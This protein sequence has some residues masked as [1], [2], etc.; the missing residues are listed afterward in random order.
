M[1]P[2]I[3]VSDWCFVSV[4]AKHLLIVVHWQVNLSTC[5]CWPNCTKQVLWYMVPTSLSKLYKNSKCCMRRLITKWATVFL[6]SY[7]S[8][9][10]A[11]DIIDLT[12]KLMFSRS[13]LT[14]IDEDASPCPR[15]YPTTCKRSRRVTTLVEFIAVDWGACKPSSKS[16]IVP[17]QWPFSTHQFWQFCRVGAPCNCPPSKSFLGDCSSI[18]Q[19]VS[20]DELAYIAANILICFDG[21]DIPGSKRAQT[22]GSVA[23]SFTYGTNFA[24]GK[25]WTLQRVCNGA[26]GRLV[27]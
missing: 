12:R 1:M 2:Y 5:T 20:V 10:I 19:F 21:Y 4:D 11:Y 14:R 24:Y 25:R 13:L 26:T 6:Y 8:K 18:S 7:E 3:Y 9:V 17:G 16:S 22:H 23:P 15:Q 27:Q